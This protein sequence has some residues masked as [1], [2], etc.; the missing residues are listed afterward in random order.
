MFDFF[1]FLN[2]RTKITETKIVKP[3]IKMASSAETMQNIAKKKD[4]DYNEQK[5]F[6][7]S[8]KLHFYHEMGSIFFKLVVVVF[9]SLPKA[10]GISC[11]PR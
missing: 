1:I 8:S 4:S 7:F 10:P 9:I 2:L 5:K 11:Y 6:F 3:F